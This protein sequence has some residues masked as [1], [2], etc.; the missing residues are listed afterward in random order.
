MSN[1][2]IDDFDSV[3]DRILREGM[4]IAAFL[5]LPV[6]VH[7]ES[8]LLTARLTKEALSAGRAGIRDYLDSRPILAE[9]DAIRRAID[10]AG[11]TGCALH[12]VH[13]SSAA[14][15]ELLTGARRAGVNATCET[16][17]HYLVLT[18]EDVERLGA[19][20]KCAPPLRTAAERDLLWRELL[21]GNILTIGSD[22]S[23]SPPEMK[24]ASNSFKVWG[25]ISGAQHLLPLLLTHGHFQRQADLTLLSRLTFA[26]VAQR[27][28]LPATKGGIAVG[29]DADL[30]LVDLG[31]SF[32]VQAGDLQYRHKQSPYVGANLRGAIRRTLLRGQAVFLDGKIVGEPQGRLDHAV[33]VTFEPFAGQ[34]HK[35]AWIRNRSSRPFALTGI[36]C[37]VPHFCCA[38]TRLMRKTSSRKRFCKAFDPFTA[39]KGARAFTPGCMPFCST[40]PA[41]IIAV[42]NGLSMTT[43]WPN[44]RRLRLLSIITNSTPARLRQRSGK[45][46]SNF[47]KI[48]GRSSCCAILKS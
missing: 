3:D 34:W 20:A 19:V 37:C 39:F 41:T 8:E 6:A 46:C 15:V 13:V 40:S 12:V 25:G 1:S 36:G 26:N 9:L 27:F 43:N 21:A 7:A 35:R 32:S 24:Q 38:A 23:P 44:A 47:P 10:L 45:P 31:A 28:K 29:C 30:A 42:E 33:S 22:H 14:G 2:G 11:E 16:C 48:T 17:P 18:D 4:K 5:K